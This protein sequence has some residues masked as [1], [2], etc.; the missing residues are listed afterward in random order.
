MIINLAGRLQDVQ[1]YVEALYNKF[2]SAE[3]SYHNLEHTQKVVQRCHEIS[4]AYFID[5]TDKFI[6]FTSAWFHDAGH[7]SGLPLNHEERSVEIMKTYFENKMD[8]TKIIDAIAGCIMAT[9]IPHDPKT[10]P[11]K[12]IADADTYNLG[13]KDFID[14]DSGVKKEL[15]LRTD[16]ALDDWNS[17]TLNMLINHAFFTAYCRELLNKGKQENIAIAIKRMQGD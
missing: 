5:E 1:S 16:L 9:K 17:K 2:Q 10:L 3:L 7:L 12:I 8:D 4:E 6:L 14:T 11:E 15:Q 13:T